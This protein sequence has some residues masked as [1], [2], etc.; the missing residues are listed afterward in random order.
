MS[1]DV[2]VADVRFLHLPESVEN[3]NID[4]VIELSD[5]TVRTATFFTLKNIASLMEKNE[6]TGECLLG[7]YLWAT[8]MII[9]HD[10]RE[11]TIREVINEI[12]RT[13]EYLHAF[14]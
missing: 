6:R 7:K 4:V 2:E 13:G 9:V 5:G 12:V 10:L 14:G 11:E 3:D 1:D 8:E